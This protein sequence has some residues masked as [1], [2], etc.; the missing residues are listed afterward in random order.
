M[1]VTLTNQSNIEMRTVKDLVEGDVIIH[2][3]IINERGEYGGTYQL[4]NVTAYL[5]T[6]TSM[7]RSYMGGIKYCHVEM[8]VLKASASSK[9]GQFKRNG[10]GKSQTHVM[11]ES[12]PVAV[13]VS[14]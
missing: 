5:V 7:N 2:T 6:D 4:I 13:A 10:L 12:D 14:A 1:S 8:E 3:D 9:M 11:P